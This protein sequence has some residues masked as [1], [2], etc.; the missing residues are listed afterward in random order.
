LHKSD[1]Q[2]VLQVADDGIG[3]SAAPGDCGSSGLGLQIVELLVKQ[4]RGSMTCQRTER[5]TFTVFVAYGEATAKDETLA[6]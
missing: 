6:I 2:L 4:L 1:G 3:L 5:T